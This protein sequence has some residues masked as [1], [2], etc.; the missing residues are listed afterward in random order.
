MRVHNNSKQIGLRAG[1]GKRKNEYVCF[2]VI[3]QKPII[4]DMAVAKSFKV[5]R[6]RMF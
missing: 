5:A 3:E 4:L 6:K 2:D 1:V